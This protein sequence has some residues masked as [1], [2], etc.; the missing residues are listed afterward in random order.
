[1]DLR[2]ATVAVTGATGFLGRY[3]VRALLQR[4]AH[5]AAVVRNPD[6]VPALRA[7]GVELRKADLADR[8]A[9]ARGFADVD[10]VLSNAAV[11]SVGAHDRETVLRTN[12]DGTR[13][14]FLA[15]ADAGVR[16][17]VYTSTATVYRPRPDHLYREEHELRSADE[18]GHRFNWYAISKAAAERE[19]WELAA[20]HGVALTT[21]RPHAIHGAFDESGATAWMRRMTRLP[22]GAWLAG[23]RFPSVYAG[24]LAEAVCRALERPVAE[25]RAYNIAGEPGAHTFWDLLRAWREAGGDAA[26]VVLP[27]PAPMTRRYAIDRAQR[28]LDFVNRPLVEGMREALALERAGAL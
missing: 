8:A 23:T 4:G 3:L 13:N 7:A 19:A 26:R 2:G 6:R 18:R 16:R 5:V 17:A 25:G 27:L 22:V 24:D 10:A 21:V 15:M 28:E 11:I 20:R 9:L 14:A 12:V 1:V